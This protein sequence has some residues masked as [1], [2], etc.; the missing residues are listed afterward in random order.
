[1]EKTNKSEIQ[2]AIGHIFVPGKFVDLTEPVNVIQ[3][4]WGLYN[5]L[6]LFRN[7][8]KTQKMVELSRTHET[9]SILED[10]QWDGRKPVLPGGENDWSLFRIPH[11]PVQDMIT[12]QDLDGNIDFDALA[13]GSITTPLT[14]QKVLYTK[15]ERMRRAAALTLEF[16]RA[17]L[18]R[19]GSVYAPNGTVVTNFYTEFGLTRE[20]FNL[21]LAN[22]TV[23]PLPKMDD[24]IGSV[25]DSVQDGEV[26]TDIVALCS[27]KF[28]QALISNPFVVESY[29]Y[30][31]QP[32]GMDILNQRLGTVAPLDRR[33]RVFNYGGIEFIEVRGGVGGVPY[34]ND[35]EAYVFPRGTDSFRTFFAPANK[36]TSINKPANELYMF[37]TMGEKDDKIELEGETNFMNAVVRPQIIKTLTVNP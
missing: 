13:R 26:H 10:V 12:P 37:S 4:K 23:N 17:Q 27:P 31:Q 28:F 33:Y 36:F 1:M 2:K 34:V 20:V 16:A 24:V 30:F 19:D 29:Q 35:G 22:L 11:F 3:N 21:D 8:Y 15:T 9:I 18:I 6:G 32:Q 5:A 25:V 7:E 14:L